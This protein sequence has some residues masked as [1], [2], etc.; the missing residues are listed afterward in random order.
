MSEQPQLVLGLESSCDDTAAAVLCIGEDVEVLSSIVRGQ[1]AAHAPFG[2]V[3]PE[4]AARAHADLIDIVAEEALAEAEVS[5]PDLSLIAATAG[6]GLIGGVM[7][8]FTFAKGLSIASG[9]PLVPVNHL[10][11]H[12]LSVG[13]EGGAELPYLLLL[14]SGGHTQLLII[15]GPGQARR[16]GTTIDDAAG[17]AFDK[18]AK[19]MGLPAPGGPAIERLARDGDAERFA[20]PRPLLGREGYDFSFSGMKTA[21]RQAAQEAAPLNEST[22]AD[23]AASFQK[24]AIAHLIRQTERALAQSGAKALVA[25]GGVASNSVLRS[26]LEAL[27]ERS[28]ASFKAPALRY[29]TDNAA[30]IA[31]AGYQLH[32]AGLAPSQEDALALAPR[33]RWPL[34]GEA[35]P[36]IGRG[37]RGAKV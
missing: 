35:A 36:V 5:V 12:A 1:D 23:L 16:L 7:A 10:E 20:M 4:I 11:G 37:K 13:L 30:M 22:K 25:A 6:P 8:G 32:A 24:A 17:E 15:E 34:D 26:E 21:V 3:V 9:V 18:T 28:G 14:V 19:L 29:C 27:A 2:G 33:P 31:L